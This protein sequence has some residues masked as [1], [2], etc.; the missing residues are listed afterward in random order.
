MRLITRFYGTVFENCDHYVVVTFGFLLLQPWPEE[1][2]HDWTLLIKIAEI[3]P[4]D[5]SYLNSLALSTFTEIGSTYQIKIQG[6][7]Q[8]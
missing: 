4:I 6:W 2:G 5:F 8:S 7:G 1:V 3:T